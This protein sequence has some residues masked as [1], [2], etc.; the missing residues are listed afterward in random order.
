MYL[1]SLHLIENQRTSLMIYLTELWN[2][3]RHFTRIQLKSRP[4][5]NR[6]QHNVEIF[7]TSSAPHPFIL[8]FRFRLAFFFCNET[9]IR[10]YTRFQ[11]FFFCTTLNHQVVLRTWWMGTGHTT[12]RFS[13]MCNQWFHLYAIWKKRVFQDSPFF[14]LKKN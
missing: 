9:S 7:P 12:R 11:P 10:I 8:F 5:Q 3:N 2:G 14:L 6:M 13:H 1:H 4:C